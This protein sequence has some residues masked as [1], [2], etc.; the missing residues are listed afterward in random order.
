VIYRIEDD[1]ACLLEYG[2]MKDLSGSYNDTADFTDTRS[3]S[4]YYCRAC[5][6]RIARQLRSGR[7]LLD[8]A[9]GL[10]P[11]V[12]QIQFS[13]HYDFRICLDFSI[14]ALHEAKAKLGAKGLYVLGDIM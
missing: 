7:Y 3:V 11:H 13:T 4:A 5:N 9:S 10:I 6:R 1:I 14:T 8:A 2:W 12:D